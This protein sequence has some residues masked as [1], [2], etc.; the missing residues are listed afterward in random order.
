MEGK[1]GQKDNSV[2]PLGVERLPTAREKFQQELGSSDP[3]TEG[4]DGKIFLLSE[5]VSI[6]LKKVRIPH[7][8]QISVWKMPTDNV[9]DS[10]SL[11]LIGAQSR[12]KQAWQ[13][14]CRN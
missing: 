4:L 1:E 7:P 3:D 5:K 8:C 6:F 13:S 14:A 2:S 9:L 12:S 10:S 11:H